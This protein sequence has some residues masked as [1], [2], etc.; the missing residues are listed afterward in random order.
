MHAK[1]DAQRRQR[2]LAQ[3]AKHRLASV[4]PDLYA[5]NNA[6]QIAQ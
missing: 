1:W 4:M 3:I 5:R 2:N 6:A